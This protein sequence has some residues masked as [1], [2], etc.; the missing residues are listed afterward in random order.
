MNIS[1]A[2]VAAMSGWVNMGYRSPPLDQLG[3]VEE[4]SAAAD[5]C[6]ATQKNSTSFNPTNPFLNKRHSQVLPASC[7]I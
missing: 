3:V 5:R 7:C 6:K 2:M 1:L 4:A